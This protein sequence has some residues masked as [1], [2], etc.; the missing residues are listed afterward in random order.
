MSFRNI[1]VDL[2]AYDGDTVKQFRNWRKLAFPLLTDWQ[3]YAFD[4]NPI[5][6]EK[7]ETKKDEHTFFEQKAAW[8]FDGEI[9]VAIDSAPEPLGTTVMPGKKKIWDVSEKITVPCFDFP[10]WLKQFRGQYI[11]VKM[12]VEGAEFPILQRMLEIGTANVPQY[13]L[14]EFHPNKVEEY[15]TED[16]I[17]LIKRL[18]RHT[19]VLE[20][21]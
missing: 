18:E 9:E 1:Y 4:P 3:I 16:K 5:F 12:D 7:W 8:I 20:W 13:L 17:D 15:T 21:H 6:K 10:L 2:G 19:K 14:V 11:V